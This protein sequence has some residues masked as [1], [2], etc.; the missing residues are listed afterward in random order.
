MMSLAIRSVERFGDRIRGCILGGRQS[1]NV[2][3]F[4][5]ES[6]FIHHDPFEC[7]SRCAEYESRCAEY[8]SRC[9]EYESRC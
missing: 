7:E 5:I 6:R 4:L 2:E 8:E 9:A 1:I 3:S